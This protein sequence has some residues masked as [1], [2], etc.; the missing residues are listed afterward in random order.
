MLAKQLHI[1]VIEDDPLFRNLLKKVLKE[2]SHVTAVEKPSQAFARLR[3]DPIDIVICDFRLPEMTGLQVMDRIKETYPDIEVIMISA[4]A[5]MDIV[6][7]ALRKGASDFFTKP[8]TSDQ[9][10]LSIERTRKFAKLQADLKQYK[11]ENLLLKEQIIKSNEYEIIGSSPQTE[12]LRH[13]INMVAQSSDTSVLIIGESGTGKE[14]V[15]RGIHEK[16]KRNNNSFHAVNMGAVPEP[17]FESE[18]FGHKKGSFTGALSDRK[19]WFEVSQKGTLF[20]DEI[21]EIPK[22]L[23]VKLLRVLEDRRYTPVG[24]QQT[25]AF[26]ARIISATNI[27]HE[28][29]TSGKYIRQDLFHRLETFIISIPPLRQRKEDIPEL[30]N[31][32]L[33]RLSINMGKCITGMHPEVLELLSQYSFPGNVRELKNILERAIIVCQDDQI[34]PEHLGPIGKVGAADRNTSGLEQVLNLVEL[35]KRAIKN[36]FDK[37]SSDS[38]WS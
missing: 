31:H 38:F 27:S 10:W 8:F 19:G 1:L 30:C 3:T 24:T 26:D 17:L 13:Q 20:L 28:E 18:F 22:P 15:A 21:G 29:I 35:E 12:Y 25:N 23:Q 14:L 9:I 37:N 16:S 11:K 32:Y 6:I 2:K 4:A 36:A 7:S 33:K 34:N 5:E